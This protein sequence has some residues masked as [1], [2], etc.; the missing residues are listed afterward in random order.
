MGCGPTLRYVVQRICLSDPSPL[1]QIPAQTRAGGIWLESAFLKDLFYGH[2]NLVIRPPQTRGEIW[3][4]GGIWLEIPLWPLG[5][6]LL[7]GCQELIDGR[8]DLEDAILDALELLLHG[9]SQC[10]TEIMLP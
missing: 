2:Q 6:L 5:L 3:L 4:E 8:L 10:R 9:L 1:L 7:H